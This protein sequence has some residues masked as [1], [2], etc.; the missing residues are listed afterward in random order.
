MHLRSAP[1]RGALVIGAVTIVPLLGPTPA[2]ADTEPAPPACDS[3][4]CHR[5]RPMVQLAHRQRRLTELH[6]AS[7]IH[8]S[9]SSVFPMLLVGAALMAGARRTVPWRGRF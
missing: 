8:D 9:G 2:A 1:L 3:P 7:R 4:G 6:R 5:T